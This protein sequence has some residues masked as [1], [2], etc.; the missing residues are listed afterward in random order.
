MKSELTLALCAGLALLT[1]RATAQDPVPAPRPADEALVER[2]A[3]LEKQRTADAAHIEAMSDELAAVTALVD[4]TVRYL[5]A[6][7]ESAADMAGTLDTS[8][9]EGFTFGINPRSREVLLEGWRARLQA[10]RRDLPGAKAVQR[11]EAVTPPSGD[12]G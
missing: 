9:Q 2:L 6:Q 11:A 12:G 3:E 7:A 1:L 4:Q 10:I 8:E 5:N